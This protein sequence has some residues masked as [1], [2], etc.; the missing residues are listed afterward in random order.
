M[1]DFHNHVLPNVDDGPESIEQ[2]I[3]MLDCACKQGITDVVNT[4]HYQHPKMLGK[5]VEYDYLNNKIEELQLAIFEKDIKVNLHLAA[6]VFYLPDL[7]KIINNPLLTIGNKKYMLIE[8]SP[9][10]FPFGYEDEFFNLQLKRISPIIAHP[11]R[12]HFIQKDISLLKIWINR[13]YVI[14]IDAG[15]ILGHFGKEIR[16]FTLAMIN[17]GYIHL[18]GSDAH[19]QKKRNF[20][21]SDAYDF[22]DSNFGKEF[23]NILKD[24]SYRVLKGDKTLN[25]NYKILKNKKNKLSF[26]DKIKNKFM[27]I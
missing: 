3:N 5:N 11:E 23:V 15:S 10:I 13:G 19:N 18:I 17:K 24:N 14:Q 25:I 21:L 9:N 27:L 12:Y 2:S 16:E 22:L 1:I 4:V 7:V 8:F 26:L 20:C 6:E